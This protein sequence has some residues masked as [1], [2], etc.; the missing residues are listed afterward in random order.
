MRVLHVAHQPPHPDAAGGTERYAGALLGAQREHGALAWSFHGPIDGARGWRASWD[1]PAVRARFRRALQRLRPDIVHVHHL[2]GLGYSL[3]DEAAASGARVVLTL[4]DHWLVCARGQRVDRDGQRCEGPSVARCARC[5]CAEVRAPL[6]PAVSTRLP[7]PRRALAARFAAWERARDAVHAFH[8]PSPHIAERIGV[9]AT[10][11]PLPLLGRS[12]AA[13][14]RTAR[15]DDALRM[16]FVGAMIPTK[17]PDLALAAF[18]RLPAGAATLQLVGPSPPWRGSTAWATALRRR[19]EATPGVRW[20]G[21][22]GPDE[23][24]DAMCAADLL[25]FPSTWEENAPL[26]LV[27]AAAVGLPALVSDVAGTWAAPNAVRVPPGDPDAW[28]RALA[29]TIGHGP[30]PPSPSSA[31]DLAAHAEAMLR[32]YGA[33]AGRISFPR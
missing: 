25:L 6:P 23:V 28:A 32:W 2:E 20:S 14:R 5:V 1:R 12:P 30:P 21:A 16:I 3:L 19:A 8:A 11:L 33:V 13:P 7:A 17:G 27:E 10:F 18:A 24:L 9:P 26:V 29:A 31:P 15:D 22:L 4:H